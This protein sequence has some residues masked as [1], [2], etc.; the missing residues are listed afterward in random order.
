VWLVLLVLAVVSAPVR[1]A[2]EPVETAPPSA[3]DLVHPDGFDASDRE[4]RRQLAR[5]LL[6]RVLLLAAVIPPQAAE[7][8]QRLEEEQA[9]LDDLGERASARRR[10]RFYLS[11]A[12]QHRQALAL[13]DGVMESLTCARDSA[14]LPGEMLCWARS[15]GYLLNED[16]LHTALGVLRDARMLPRDADMPV[17]ARH[18]LVWYGEYGRGILTLVVIPH[19]E[20]LAG[21][22][23]P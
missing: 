3:W 13:L 10:A 21:E 2:E 12:Y 19:L 22:S 1:A 8:L 4:Q 20:A 14:D 23:S 9:A 18:P 11:R 5:D 15:S 6:D 7:Q 16:R 17:E